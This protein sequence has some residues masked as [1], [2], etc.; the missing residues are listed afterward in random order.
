MDRGAV[1]LSLGHLQDGLVSF[2]RHAGK[3]RAEPLEPARESLQVL[4]RLLAGAARLEM[5]HVGRRA[6]PGPQGV[7]SKK[8]EVAVG[9]RVL[10]TFL[11]QPGRSKSS[12]ILLFFPPEL[13]Q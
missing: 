5:R 1:E 12:R 6:L 4:E 3:P 2:S 9:L 10:H 11:E 8:V 7:E 13:L